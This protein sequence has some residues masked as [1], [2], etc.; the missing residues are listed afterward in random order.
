MGQD[1][2]GL[3]EQPFSGLAA[4]DQSEGAQRDANIAGCAPPARELELLLCELTGLLRLAEAVVGECGFGPPRRERGVL[5][6]KGAGEVAGGTEFRQRLLRRTAVESDKP[7]D[8][9]EVEEV[10][11][12]C[13]GGWPLDQP[14]RLG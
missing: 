8:A 9:Q 13:H 7:A 1:V 10:P 6:P 12:L 4:L 3:P 5:D 11:L 14:L 2:D